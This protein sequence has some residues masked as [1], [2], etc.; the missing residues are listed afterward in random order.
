VKPWPQAPSLS[1]ELVKP[2]SGRGTFLSS[3]SILQLLEKRDFT[4][5]WKILIFLFAIKEINQ[6]PRLLPNIT[7]GYNIY[8][9]YF[10]ARM[11]SEA[12]VD[13]LSTSQAHVPNYK[14]GRQNQMLAILESSDSDNSIQLSN[15]MGIYK[16]PQVTYA[17]TSQVLPDKTT[18]RFRYSMVPEDGI[19][20]PGIVK[21]LL[22]F[23]WTVVGLLSLDSDNGEKFMSTMKP[24]LLRNGIC[25]LFSL[26]FQKQRSIHVDFNYESAKKLIDINVFVHFAENYVWS[27]GMELLEAAIAFWMKPIAGKVWITTS[28]SDLDEDL[29]Y[30]TVDVQYVAI[31]CPSP[32]VW[33]AATRDSSRWLGKESPFAAMTVCLVQKGP[34]PLGKVTRTQ[35]IYSFI[36]HHQHLE[37]DLDFN[38]KPVKLTEDW[39]HVNIMP[40]P[41]QQH[42]SSILNQLKYPDSLQV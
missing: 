2:H 4:E 11:T 20:Y 7:V 13:L 24:E 35:A 37:L 9:N 1:G 3:S 10:D 21:L 22:H 41:R 17:F 29:A 6:N 18:S 32:S 19:Q 15:M 26:N 5:F 40:S 16:I 36:G 8:E 42:G 39:S 25:V 34:S 23:R 31:P 33:K 12:G 14:C 28:L 38:G 27:Y 30:T